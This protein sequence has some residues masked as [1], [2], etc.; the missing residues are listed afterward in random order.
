MGFSNDDALAAL[1]VTNDNV[2][3]ATSWLLGERHIVLGMR[4]RT[5]VR[6]DVE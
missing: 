5:E 3:A 4:G 1:R 6:D 2:E